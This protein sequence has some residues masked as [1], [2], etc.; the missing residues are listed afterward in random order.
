MKL[1]QRRKKEKLDIKTEVMVHYSGQNPPKCAR[2]CTTAISRLT[3]DHINNDG[4]EMRNRYPYQKRHMLRWLMKNGYPEG[5]QV[6]CKRCNREKNLR[7]EVFLAGE[8][9]Q[10]SIKETEEEL[11]AEVVF[12]VPKTMENILMSGKLKADHVSIITKK[13]KDSET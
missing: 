1:N 9:V 2:C 3:I 7:N 4:A 5:Y 11:I 12:P 10:D 8:I 6:L 13:F